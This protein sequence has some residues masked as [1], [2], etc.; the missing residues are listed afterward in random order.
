LC[1]KNN[2][3][4]SIIS[5]TFQGKLIVETFSLLKDSDKPAYKD[6]IIEMD[7]IRYRYEIKQ[8]NFLYFIS[9][10]I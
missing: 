1:K 6:K 8:Q 4:K 2:C 9:I 10:I 3:N 5:E 7:G